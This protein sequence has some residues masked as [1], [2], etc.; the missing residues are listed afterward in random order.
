VAAKGN[1]QP[2]LVGL[3]S[4]FSANQP[5]LYVDVDRVKAKKQGVTLSDVFD[6]LQIY[7]GSAYVNDITLF[8]RNWQVNVQ[9]DARYRLR[10]EDVGKL[11]VRNA[12]G[13]M[14][15]LDTMITV[16]DV[17]GPAI[18]NHYNSK[19]SAEISGNTAPGVSSGQAIA[20]M[21][22]ISRQELPA[23]MGIEWTEL[24]YQQI[25]AGKGLLTKLG[26]PLAVGVGFLVPAVR[27]A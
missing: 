3:F 1:S 2:G 10:P 22:Q 8:N 9:A 5:Q 11:K 12:S 26:F 16:T 19:P 27:G 23:G 7:L 14:V 15:P 17:A 4:S 21:E 6:T 20:L 13:A 24:T 18:V 25:E